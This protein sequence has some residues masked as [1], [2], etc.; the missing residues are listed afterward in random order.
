MSELD[1][2]ERGL[3]EA[4]E[5]GKLGPG[6]DKAELQRLKAAACATAIKDNRPKNS[7]ATSTVAMAVVLPAT[8]AG[9]VDAG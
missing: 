4:Y 2:Y 7:S 6:A 8:P 9:A 1:P 3:L 5:S